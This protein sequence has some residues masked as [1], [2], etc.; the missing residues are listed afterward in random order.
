MKQIALGNT[1]WKASAIALGCMRITSLSGAECE[2][3]VRGAMEEGIDFFDHADIY[4]GGEAE[5]FF[6]ESVH[7]NPA[8]REKMYIQSK[9]GIRPGRYDFS[10][11]YILSS[12]EGSLRRLQ[13]DYLDVLLLHRPDALM[14]PEEVAEAF[15]RLQQEGKVRY[16]GVSNQNPAQIALLQKYMSQKLIVN[17]LQLSVTNC[18]MID[19]GL[20][21]NMEN[22][23]AVMRDGSVLDY[24]RLNDITI[25]A[26]SPF[27]YGFFE[28]VFIDNPKFPAL[29]A[30]LEEL[31]QR[32]QAT[33]NAV[34]IAWILRHP[35]NIQAILG[36]TNLQRVKDV[37]K[38]SEIR[39]TR[40]EW[41]ELYLSVGKQLP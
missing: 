10:K 11:E 13:T 18:T 14:E 30:K 22:A 36:T 15:T 32:Y 38:A 23:P 20:N 40:E 41:Y 9:C 2:A 12:V 4:A 19:Q 37:C 25:Q 17:Q 5:S 31:A 16:F 29:N 3:L 33:K 8:L 27:Q 7:M 21:V 1:D 6:A 28:G 34:A 39:L 24:C 26:W 35:A